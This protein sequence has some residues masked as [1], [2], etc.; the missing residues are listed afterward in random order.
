[1][2]IV[3]YFTIFNGFLLLGFILL[4]LAILLDLIIGDPRWL[5]H[6]VIQ[7]GKLISFLEQSWNKGE[8]RKIKGVFLTIAVLCVVF[9]ITYFILFFAYQFHFLAGFLLEI[10][11]ISTTIAIKGLH[12]AAKSVFVPLVE[13]NLDE[14]RFQLSM[15]VGRDTEKLNESEIVR[16]TV[17]TVAENTVDGIT[18]PLFWAFIG[19]AP[20]AMVYRA[21]NTLDSMVGYKS[22]S[23]IQF[24]WASARFD[25]VMNY[26]PSR[27]TAFA[28]W[29][30]SFFMKGPKRKE[31]LHITKRDAKKHP[32][33]NS[34]YPEAMVAGLIGIQ[35]GGVNYYKGV[36]SKRATMGEA[37]R[38]LVAKDINRSILYMHGGWIVF[39]I[40]L[41]GLM[42]IKTMVLNEV[43][44]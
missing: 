12:S 30:A 16:G 13:G 44:Q 41:F 17:E 37:T 10:Y 24:G 15:I 9:A 39:V 2:I 28:M 27:L 20:L 23:Y 33:P 18:A 38:S 22:E 1:M 43:K 35:L 21:T 8:Y 3:D 34:G 5:P 29:L 19:G 32:S 26:I 6:P 11:L 25:D 4:I 7:I 14:A 42:L 40:F 31:A 36:E